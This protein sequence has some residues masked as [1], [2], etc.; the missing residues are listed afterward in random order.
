MGDEVVVIL[1]ET[2]GLLPMLEGIYIADNQLTDVS[3]VPFIRN[4]RQCS[5]LC[6]LDLSR[7]KLDRNA[8]E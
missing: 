4:L 6:E 2:I 5:Q 3:L 1:A 7:N 8:A